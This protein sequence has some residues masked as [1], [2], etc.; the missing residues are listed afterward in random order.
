MELLSLFLSSNDQYS[1]E[2]WCCDQMDFANK[3]LNPFELDDI[4]CTQPNYEIDPDF[5]HFNDVNISNVSKCNYYFRESLS[6]LLRTR[7]V[8]NEFSVMYHNIRSLPAKLSEFTIFL[9]EIQHTFS[10]IGISE[11]WLNEDNVN[12]YGIS[13]YE[14]F[15][16]VLA[17]VVV[18]YL[19]LWRTISL[20]TDVMISQCVTIM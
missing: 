6:K 15:H 10:I 18:G 12:L 8:M 2:Y 19:L 16:N 5:Y 14:S 7:G 3:I 1:P 4:E 13:G 17:D 20:V 9:E 11:T